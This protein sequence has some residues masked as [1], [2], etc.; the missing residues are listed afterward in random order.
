MNQEFK[1]D[2]SCTRGQATSFIREWKI[3]HPDYHLR[4]NN[5]QDFVK[6]L[7]EELENN[8]TKRKKRQTNESS[9]SQ[10]VFTSA[11]PSHIFLSNRKSVVLYGPLI[12][13]S[14][15]FTMN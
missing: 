13:T 11:A 1:G 7:I 2:S 6:A 5:C 3:D 15:V 4:A 14:I 9:N 12:L 8:C 10:C